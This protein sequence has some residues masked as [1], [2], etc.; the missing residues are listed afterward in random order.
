MI[1]HTMIMTFLVAFCGCQTGPGMGRPGHIDTG[2]SVRST[3]TQYPQVGD[4]WIVA[5]PDLTE[6]VSHQSLEPTASGSGPAGTH[7]GAF[8]TVRP[9]NSAE[10]AIS[11]S[12]NDALVA[13]GAPA[14][15]LDRI[16][17]RTVN[18][19]VYLTGQVMTQAEKNFVEETTSRLPGVR[20]VHNHLR[21]T[22]G[23]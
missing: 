8:P 15:A 10:R 14:R 22:T 2:T 21:L 7:L 9:E 11:R 3:S 16:H 5:H 23:R 17:V 13:S 6:A 12:V 20:A 4:H 19:E 18:G 1:K